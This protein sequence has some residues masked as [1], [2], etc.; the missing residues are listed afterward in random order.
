MFHGKAG[1][2]FFGFALGTA[3]AAA[4]IGLSLVGVA[5]GV[6]LRTDAPFV[7]TQHPL[8]IA[9]SQLVSSSLLAGLPLFAVWWMWRKQ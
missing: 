5:V 2:L 1:F 3:I 4:L 9:G 6:G 7:L 8:F